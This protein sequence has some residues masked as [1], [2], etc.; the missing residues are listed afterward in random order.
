MADSIEV[1]SPWV[2]LVTRRNDNFFNCP[3]KFIKVA[4]VALSWQTKFGDSR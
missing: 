4:M 2:I 1:A 3:E